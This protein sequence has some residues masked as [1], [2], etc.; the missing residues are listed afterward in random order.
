[1]TYEPLSPV[2][3]EAKLRALVTALTQAQQT[4]SKARDA[5]VDAEIALMRAR[6]EIAKAAPKVA[7]GEFTVAERE[8]W[9]DTAVRDEWEVLRRAETERKNAE[10]LLRVTRDQA[11]V[12]QSLARGVDTAYRLAGAA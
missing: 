5:E 2:A 9:I 10:D 1:M 11:S 4:L 12:V 6:D 7:R 8:A 3:V